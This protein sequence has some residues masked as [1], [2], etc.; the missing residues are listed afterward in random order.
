MQDEKSNLAYARKYRPRNINEYMGES[1]RNILLN[2]FSDVK[3]F[4]QTILI[5]GTRGTG[6]TSAARIISKEYHCMNRSETGHAC[7]HCEMCVEIDEKLISSEAGVTAMGVQEVD[8]ASDSGKANIDSILEEALIEPMYP[9][10]YKVLILDEFHMA[11]KQAQNRLLKILEEPPKHLVFILC[12]TNPESI[13]DT[14]LSRC[15]LKIEVKKASVE[16]LANR[17]LYVC[18]QE[19]IKTSMEALRIIAKKADRVPREALMLLESIAKNYGYNVTLE[20]V[21]KQTGD[22]SATLYMDYYKAANES[23]ESI[24]LFNQK[25]KEQEISPKDF[26]RGLTR[27]TL[28]CLYIK[29]AIGIEDYPPD[30]VKSVKGLFKLYNSGELDTLLQI[31]EYAYKI[32][33]ADDTKAELVV[34]TTAMRIGKVQ[35]LSL[36]LTG[37]DLEAEKENKASMIN[38]KGLIKADAEKSKEVK[39]GAAQESMLISIFGKEA[40]GLSAKSL[41]IQI[42]EEASSKEIA[43]EKKDE[44]DRMMDDNDLFEMFGKLV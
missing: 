43:L 1:I 13:I 12:T 4:P 41:D 2:R 6:K 32:I 33:D 37:Q 21:Q 7:G 42:P 20:N 23:L 11:T 36:G 29:Y 38:Y 9:L 16:E 10:K 35:S 25:L 34:T 24:L 26:I 28:E 30:Y 39:L 40:E 31:I 14:I 22:V 19:K 27:F 3:N 18:Q 5:H 15:Q 8:I 17:L 44:Q